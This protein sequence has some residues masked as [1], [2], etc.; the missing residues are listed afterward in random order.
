MTSGGRI[1]VN[2]VLLIADDARLRIAGAIKPS[3]TAPLGLVAQLDMS[4]G[5]LGALIADARSKPADYGTLQQLIMLQAVGTAGSDPD[6]E[7]VLRFALDINQ[8]GQIL[9]NGSDLVP[10]L[11]A[12]SP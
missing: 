12:A 1:E 8:L 9:L 5:G 3:H 10:A 11:A 6:G 7:P 2:E 4:I